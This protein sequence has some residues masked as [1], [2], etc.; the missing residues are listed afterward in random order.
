MQQVLLT[1]CESVFGQ[2]YLSSGDVM[3]R[4]SMQG[5]TEDNM[6]LFACILGWGALIQFLLTGKN[7]LSI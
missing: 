3:M 5:I 2:V 1:L 6:C 4:S 7:I